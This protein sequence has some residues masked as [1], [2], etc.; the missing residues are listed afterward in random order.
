MIPM[1]ELTWE[2]LGRQ[3]Y[4]PV[5]A[6]QLALREQILAGVGEP[7]LWLLEHEPVVTL[8]RRTADDALTMPVEWMQRHGVELVEIERGG[9]ATYHGPGQLV[10][11]VILPVDRFGLTVPRLVAH[12]EGCVIDFAARRGVGAGRRDGFP[13]VWVQRSKI[14]A[15]GLHLHRLVTIHGFAFNLTVDLTPYSYI[16]PCGITPDQGRVS[17]LAELG[18][19]AP[20]PEQAA[21]EI[22]ADLVARLTSPAMQR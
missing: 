13:G 4:R 10:G 18:V 9:A 1:R 7:R 6:Q 15:V 5:Y 11:Y 22:A 16:V 17:S 8:G 19:D 3:P 14:A 12:L 21:P 20:S 2:W